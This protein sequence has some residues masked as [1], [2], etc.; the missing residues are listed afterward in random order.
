MVDFVKNNNTED[1]IK[2]NFSSE[3]EEDNIILLPENYTKKILDNILEY[4]LV[5]FQFENIPK[6]KIKNEQ[7][8]IINSKVIPQNNINNQ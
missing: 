5:D 3:K 8:Q 7:N 1:L 2:E 4:I 6:E